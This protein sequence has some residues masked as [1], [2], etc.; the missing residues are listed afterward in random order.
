MHPMELLLRP[1][2]TAPV[3]ASVGDRY[4]W[5]VAERWRETS[6]NRRLSKKTLDRRT[7][8]WS[9]G[10]VLYELLTVPGVAP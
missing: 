9:F 6:S 7:D 10:A 8:I 3:P 4:E 2:W 1:L 5:H